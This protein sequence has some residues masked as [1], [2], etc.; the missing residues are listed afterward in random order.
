[1]AQPVPGRDI[2]GGVAVS[3]VLSMLK[4]AYSLLES[5]REGEKLGSR[6]W[7][8]TRPVVAAAVTVPVPMSCFQAE[9][10]S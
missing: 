5:A 4:S 1:M 3:R 9:A 7:P 10:S 8:K 6:G 2:G